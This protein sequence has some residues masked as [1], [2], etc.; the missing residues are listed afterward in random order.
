MTQLSELVKLAEEMV[1]LDYSIADL[2]ESRKALVDLRRKIEESDLPEAMEAAE[3]ESFTMKDGRKVT[4]KISTHTHISK[5][6]EEDAFSWLRKWGH[7]D[8]IKRIISISFGK[9]EDDKAEKLFKYLTDRKNLSDNSI[10]GKQSVHAGTLKSFVTKALA[11]GEEIP[12]ELFGVHQSTI[13]VIGSVK[14]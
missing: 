14:R 11:A 3:C 5:D 4:T 12:Q 9:G 1:K 13:A 6:H 7:D 2:D 8:I 10:I